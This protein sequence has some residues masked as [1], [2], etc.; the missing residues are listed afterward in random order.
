MGQYSV[1]SGIQ[2]LDR[3]IAIIDAISQGDKTLAELGD[4][5]S[6]PRA[7]THRLATALEIHQILDRTTQGAW[8]IGPALAHFHSNTP[9]RLINIATPIMDE[10]V[11]T[12]GESVQLYKLTG[13]TRTCIAAIE[14]P[15]GLQ[16]TVPVGSRLPLTHGSAA[17]VFAAFT[18]HL[19]IDDPFAP[20][21]LAK[22]RESG[23]AE[24][25]SER[26]VGLAS[27]SA[28]IFAGNQEIIAVLSVSGPAERLRPSPADK[29]G[30]ELVAAAEQLTRAL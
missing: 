8:T 1:E 26:E 11:D 27:V 23:L 16:N 7:T 18:E 6:I 2:V 3:A 15:S 12:T 4:A 29:W 20:D 5:T 28:P 10:L 21:D 25:V 24:S 22:V 17:R 30:K 13:T 14:P 19:L 9:T